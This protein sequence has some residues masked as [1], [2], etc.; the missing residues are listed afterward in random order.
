VYA[1]VLLNRVKDHIRQF[2]WT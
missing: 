2:R 1:H